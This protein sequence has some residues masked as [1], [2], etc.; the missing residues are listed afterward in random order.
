MNL[1]DQLISFLF[2]LFS[3]SLEIFL[4]HSLAPWLKLCIVISDQYIPMLSIGVNHG[5]KFGAI[6]TEYVN[7]Y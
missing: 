4:E 2:C 1:F 6:I 7:H 3:G 5:K